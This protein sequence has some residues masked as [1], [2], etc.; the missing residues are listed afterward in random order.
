MR[1]IPDK[2]NEITG[3]QTYEKNNVGMSSSEVLIYP[4]YVLKIQK[5]TLETENESEMVTWLKNRIPVPEILLYYVEN[6]T[7][8]T[9]MTKIIGKMLCDEEY[10]NQPEKLI[11]LVAD[12]L[13]MLWNVKI[14]DCPCNVSRL[15]ERLKSARWNVENKMVDM[16]NTE[17]ET[18]GEN[19]F[20]D[21]MELLIWLEHN[22][23]EED[24]VLTHGDLCLPNLFVNQNRISGFIDL[25]KMGPADRWQDI[26]IA[27]RSL[28][29]N[30]AGNYNGGKR[31]FK[32]EPQMLLNELDMKINETK[33]RYY[34]LL[35]ELF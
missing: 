22:Q 7:A 15:T 1:Y 12:G 2:I 26:A 34:L 30:F 25:G 35:D 13:K 20:S 27:L 6:G 5:Q 11:H 23:P 33:K 21:A 29:H 16:D 17:P 9:L 14:D 32:F 10:L 3:N 28:E 31:Y 8:Y 19:G 4:K 18:F 24:L